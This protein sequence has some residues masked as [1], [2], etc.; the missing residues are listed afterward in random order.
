MAEFCGNSAGDGVTNA[1]GV[2]KGN[3]GGGASLSVK[4]KGST[5]TTALA[6]FFFP[7]IV[8]IV[9]RGFIVEL[10]MDVT[11]SFV[12]VVSK[13]VALEG[14]ATVETFPERTFLVG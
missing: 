2:V 8:S 4:S 12:V 5:I 14:D 11:T 13:R 3:R 9:S 7:L 1:G 10:V 6:A